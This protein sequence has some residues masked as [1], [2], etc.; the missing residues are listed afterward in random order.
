MRDKTALKLTHQVY[1]TVHIIL[2]WEVN[3]SSFQLSND[4]ICFF[5]VSLGRCH[6]GYCVVSDGGKG[7]DVAVVKR[8]VLKFF[9]KRMKNQCSAEELFLLKAERLKLL[10]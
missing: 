10:L 7:I 8:S 5:W 3:T 6:G 4:Y 1:S 9:C 2:W